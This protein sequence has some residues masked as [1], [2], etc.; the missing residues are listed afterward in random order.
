MVC[1]YGGLFIFLAGSGFVLIGTLGLPPAPAGALMST[2]AMAYIGGTLLCRRWIPGL[3]LA[4][5]VGRA[6]WCTLA[7]CVALLLLSQQPDPSPLA[8]MAPVWLYA[9][10]HGVHM[11]CGQAG[12]VGPFPH[13]AG[14]VSALAG[15]A[16]AAVAF[17]IGLWLGQA[18]APGAAGGAVRAF[19]LGMAGAALATVVVAWTLVRRH[20]DRL[21]AP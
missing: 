15:F 14:L 9:L 8:V 17:G 6:A 3:G 7:A 16:M 18:L 1:S 21:Q 19:A 20:G 5:A 12:V 11:P 13:A 2:C 10:G 4:G